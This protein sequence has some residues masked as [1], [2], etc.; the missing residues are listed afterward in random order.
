MLHFGHWIG[1]EEF[2]FMWNLPCPQCRQNHQLS[3]WGIHDLRYNV[4]NW[5]SAA[6]STIPPGSSVA[7][8]PE[9]LYVCGVEPAYWLLNFTDKCAP[10][11]E[12]SLK[13]TGLH[14]AVTKDHR[15]SLAELLSKIPQEL[16]DFVENRK[17]LREE[18]ETR[19]PLS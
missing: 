18:E 11:G 2:F 1:N 17:E 13:F 10:L 3:V 9:V 5:S 16:R 8:P 7:Y 6:W 14:Y 19:P 15:F 12:V 4:S